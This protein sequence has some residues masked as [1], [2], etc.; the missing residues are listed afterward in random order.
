M[1][2][3]HTCQEW[4]TIVQSQ[5]DKGLNKYLSGLCHEGRL[6]SPDTVKKKLA[7]QSRCKK[8]TC[9]ELPQG[10]VRQMMWSEFCPG[11][12]HN[13]N[14]GMHLRGCTAAQSC[15]VSAGELPQVIWWAMTI[16][17]QMTYSLD[18]ILCRQSPAI[19]HHTW[20]LWSTP[21][22]KQSASINLQVCS[23]QT[24]EFCRLPGL[25]YINETWWYF[26]YHTPSCTSLL[27][28][29]EVALPDVSLYHL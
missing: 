4:V 7:R 18:P 13:P 3:R 2:Q 20:L 1:F 9:S 8:D 14:L 23:S 5:V 29:C 15:W 24:S 25:W 28:R 19:S 12:S 26:K 27:R 21:L 11:R 10:Y 17:Y 6:V 22:N 16:S